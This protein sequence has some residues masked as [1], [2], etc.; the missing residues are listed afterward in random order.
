MGAMGEG[1]RGPSPQLL[2]ALSQHDVMVLNL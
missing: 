1:V 2:L